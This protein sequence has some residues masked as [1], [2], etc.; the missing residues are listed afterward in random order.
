MEDA[1]TTL[2]N[3]QVGDKKYGFF[4]V[5]DGHGGS[6]AAKYAGLHLSENIA[7][8]ELFTSD[9]KEALRLGFH[10]TDA[11]LRAGMNSLLDPAAEKEPSGCTTVVTVITP[12]NDI[13]CANAGD[14][15]AVLS[16]AGTA[17][18]LSN[19][20]KPLNHEEYNRIVAA[21][22]FVEFGRVNGNYYNQ[23]AKGRTFSN[24]LGNLALSRALGDFNFKE[25]PSLPVEEQIVT[26]NPEIIQV[27]NQPT[28]EFIVVA[29]DGILY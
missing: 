26:C 6:F 2:D 18:P 1:H 11:D 17:I 10:K 15:R 21:G 23:P 7:K 25:N 20:H 14:S 12:E 29:C 3:L 22:G 8:Q 9:I 4:G 24:I 28:N 5:Y 16:Q 13:I 27:N 19:D